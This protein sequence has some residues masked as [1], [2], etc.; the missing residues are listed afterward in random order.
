M[1]SR[2]PDGE[3][4]PVTGVSTKKKASNDRRQFWIAGLV[5]GLSL[6]AVAVIVSVASDKP[7]TRQDSQGQLQEQGG[8]KPHIIPL[9]NSGHAPERPGDRGGWEQYM[10]LALIVAGVGLVALL[11]WRGTR[12]PSSGRQAW[13]A[14]ARQSEAERAAA[15]AG[16]TD[17]PGRATDDRAPP[18][19]S[20][21]A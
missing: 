7:S 12:R 10:T 14:A 3:H 1:A 21:G 8:A 15:E 16:G 17:A 13:L 9:P 6:L 19:G 20:A 4:G 11:V 2:R 5:I 18:V